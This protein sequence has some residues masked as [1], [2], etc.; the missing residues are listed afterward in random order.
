MKHMTSPEI[1]HSMH[2]PGGRFAMCEGRSARRRKGPAGGAALLLIVSLMVLGLPG[3]AQAQGFDEQ[4]TSPVLDPT[5]TV[6]PGVRIASGFPPPANDYSLTANPGHLRYSLNEMTHGDGFVN[7]YMPAL[8]GEHSC[9]THDPGLE[10]HRTFGGTDWLLETKVSYHMPFANG[11]QL[12]LRVY[13]G[14]GGPGTLFVHVR[15]VRDVNQNHLDW[16]LREQ[17]GTTIP[18]LMTLE[19]ASVDLPLFDGT[20]TTHFFRLERAG[21]V[22][23]AMFSGDGV[24][25][26][27]AWS[28]DFGSALD[29]LDQRVVITGLSWFVPAGSFADYDYITVI[30]TVIPVDIDI[31]PGSFPSSINPRSKGVIPVAILTTDTFDATTV[32]PTTV[33]FGRTGSEASPVQSA[34]KDVD[35]D[36]D[37]DMILYFDTQATGIQCGDTSASLTG[38]TFSGQMIQGSDSINTAGCK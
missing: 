38:K 9:C 6:V 7:G 23:T 28:H 36:G 3:T 30:P 27:T 2:R 5:W 22:L 14:D 20:D 19:F 24:T 16:I 18:S 1:E 26:N 17:T 8:P 25:W 11:R 4:F 35:G 21:G 10:L 31:K 29:G 37:T 33:H 34:L 32:D 13:F 12:D 15:R